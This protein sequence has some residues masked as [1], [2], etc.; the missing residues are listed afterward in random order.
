ML[1][2]AL[3]GEYVM[4]SLMRMPMSFNDLW[5]FAAL[6]SVAGLA[7]LVPR[8]VT[9]SLRTR[10]LVSLLII[11]AL[12]VMR[13][14]VSW[15][16]QSPVGILIVLAPLPALFV[17][18]VAAFLIAPPRA[19]SRLGA[20]LLVSVTVHFFFMWWSYG[21][22]TDLMLRLTAPQVI[23]FF[24]AISMLLVTDNMIKTKNQNISASAIPADAARRDAVR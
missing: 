18:C 7:Y 14:W 20:V 16:I 8:S 4:L 1:A 13:V 3:L 15:Y 19:P 17:F 12:A 6:W 11:S 9:R 21:F 24:A 10:I 22:D 2:A 23:P 5:L